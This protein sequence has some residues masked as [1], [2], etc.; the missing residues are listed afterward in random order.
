M[1]GAS[2][3]HVSHLE[4]PLVSHVEQLGSSQGTQA[5]PRRVNLSAQLLQTPAPAGQ[6]KQVGQRSLQGR[7]LKRES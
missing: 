7:R 1:L 6:K 3:K 4:G 2:P 5:P